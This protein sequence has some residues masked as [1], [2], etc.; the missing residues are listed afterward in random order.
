LPEARRGEETRADMLILNGAGRNLPVEVKRH[1]HLDIWTAAATQL[2]DYTADPGAD[3]FGVYLVFWFG[4]DATPTP[5][6]PDGGPGPTS[7]RELEA[8]LTDDLTPE[9]GARTDVIVFDVS[10]PSAA[11][12]T[13]PRRRRAQRSSN[14]RTTRKRR[15]AIADR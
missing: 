4:N 5:A 13:K 2:Q 12:L 15:P 6:R 10:D 11:G 9:L 3:G 14:Q 7:A 8:L 1:F